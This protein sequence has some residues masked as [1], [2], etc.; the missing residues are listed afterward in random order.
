MKC[1]EEKIM[2]FEYHKLIMAKFGSYLAFS[3]AINLSQPHLANIAYGKR[4]GTF[5]QWKKIQNVLKIKDED[6]WRIMSEGITD[7][8]FDE[9]KEK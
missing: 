5:E 3:K 6:M 9:T 7:F 8:M 4:N 1:N 2:R